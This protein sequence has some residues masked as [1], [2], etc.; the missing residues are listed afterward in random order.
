MGEVTNL[1]SDLG[2]TPTPGSVMPK[3]LL[4]ILDARIAAGQLQPDAAQQR[5]L[6]RLDQLA[7]E[8]RAWSPAGKGIFGGL[9]ASKAPP[10][11]GLY[12][13][14]KVGRGKTMLMDLFHE[15]VTFKPR[16]RIHFHAFMSEV[17]KAIAEARAT[18]DGDPIP[19]VAEKIADGAHLLC[20]D[21]FH[22]TDIADAM[23]LGRLFAGLFERQVIVVAT[24]NVPPSGL[25]KNGLNRQLFEPFI[26]MIE[27]RMDV[28][29]LESA[30]DFRL[31]KLAGQP[32]YFSPV[33]A[34]SDAALRAAFTRLT[35]RAKGDP[36][37]L[38]VNGRKVRINEMAEGTAFVTFEDLCARPLGA[39]DYLHMAEAF[40]TVIVS[41]V[42]ILSR[43]RRAEARRFITLIDTLYDAHVG[44]I[45]SAAAEPD[46]LHP[47]GDESFLFER[48]ASRLIEMRSAAY[49]DARRVPKQDTA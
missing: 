13:H 41:G 27:A 33:N 8:L 30:K 14:G 15:A 43:E 1:V 3:S 2:Q 23:I 44:L 46:A 40:H 36:R 5:A 29:E 21:E 31:E 6:L 48:T 9:F 28:L 4:E 49:L 45:V 20:F 19:Y 42:P 34:R 11:R 7:A 39:E 18:V 47:A 35:G 10:P 22:V 12:I 26:R 24:S 16:R 37:D 25:Y 38:D 17:H 32:L